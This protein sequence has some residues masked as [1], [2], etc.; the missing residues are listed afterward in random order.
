MLPTR[1]FLM[2]MMGAPVKGGNIMHV[3]SSLRPLTPLPESDRKCPPSLLLLRR[4]H[5]TKNLL[6]CFVRQLADALRAIRAWM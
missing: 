4:M 3:F 5:L 2:S 1:S 6:L